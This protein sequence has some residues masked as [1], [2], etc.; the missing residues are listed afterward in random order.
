MARH[1]APFVLYPDGLAMAA[2]LRRSAAEKIAALPDEDR[3]RFMERHGLESPSPAINLPH[4]LLES[5]NG[6]GAYFNRDIG[7]EIM[8]EFNDILAALKKKG[9]G[10]RADEQHGIRRWMMSRSVSPG[11][12]RRLVEEHGSESIVTAFSL[13]QQNADYTLEYLLRRYKGQ[14]W[15]P[16]YPTLTLVK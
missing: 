6:I 12:V 2:D 8:P 13:D 9:S 10:L 1:G 5:K 14:S 16:R 7:L 4:D 15:R 3:Q 11:F